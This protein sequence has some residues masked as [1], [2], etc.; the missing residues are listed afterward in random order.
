[1]P[2]MISNQITVC[3]MLNH[4]LLSLVAG[5]HTFVQCW[6]KHPCTCQK[7]INHKA[8]KT[9]SSI[10]TSTAYTADLSPDGQLLGLHKKLETTL[11]LLQAALA[12]TKVEAAASCPA[13]L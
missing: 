7:G 2:E 10:T 3:H 13:H 1:M 12:L 4:K 9:S 8:N 6:M 5:K 11:G